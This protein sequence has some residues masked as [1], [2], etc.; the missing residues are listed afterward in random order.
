MSKII[1]EAKN[2]SKSFRAI[3]SE[4]QT[5]IIHQLNFQVVSASTLAIVGASGAGKSTLLHLLGGLDKPD[6]GQV[7]PQNHS[8][9]R[10][11]ELAL[12][13]IFI[14]STHRL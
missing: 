3:E 1:I 14:Y 6:S 12:R 10:N 7:F 9:R 8:R 2:L 4:P 11:Y 5:P 13:R